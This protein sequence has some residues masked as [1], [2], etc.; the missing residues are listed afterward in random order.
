MVI[1]ESINGYVYGN[2][3]DREVVGGGSEENYTSAIRKWPSSQLLNQYE[4]SKVAQWLMWIVSLIGK[5]WL[6]L[7]IH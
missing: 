7:L 6:V 3:N 5:K 2:E 4:K 1:A